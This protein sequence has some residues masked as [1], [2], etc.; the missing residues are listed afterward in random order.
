MPPPSPSGSQQAIG[1][2]RALGIQKSQTKREEKC[3]KR[4]KKVFQPAQQLE[5]GL[6]TQQDFFL[7]AL[8]TFLLHKNFR[9]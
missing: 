2:P 9:K 6:N 4:A 8:Q 5:V 7:S 1:W 3:W